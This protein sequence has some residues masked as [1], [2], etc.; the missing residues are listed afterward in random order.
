[1]ENTSLVRVLATRINEMVNIPLI[2]EDNEQIF[3][4]LIV[5][6]LLQIFFNTLDM[7]VDI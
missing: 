7:D 2:N 5:G 6:I 3:F 1:M 4:E